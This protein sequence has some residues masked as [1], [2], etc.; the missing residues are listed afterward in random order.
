MVVNRRQDDFPH[1]DWDLEFTL[2]HRRIQNRFCDQMRVGGISNNCLHVLVKVVR[3][4]S[5]RIGIAV[6]QNPDQV[7]R[8]KRPMFQPTFEEAPS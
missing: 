6:G 8:S 4:S 7:F 3:D 5:H 1:L 2:R